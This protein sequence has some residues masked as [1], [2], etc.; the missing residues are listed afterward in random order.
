VQFSDP[1]VML[2]F[3]HMHNYPHG[4]GGKHLWGALQRYVDVLGKSAIKAIDTG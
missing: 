2:S 3:D 1:H 4:F